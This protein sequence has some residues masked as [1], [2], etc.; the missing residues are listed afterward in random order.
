[1]RDDTREGKVLRV[2]QNDEC[3]IVQ[4][5][6]GQLERFTLIP[7]GDSWSIVARSWRCSDCEGNGRVGKNAGGAAGTACPSGEG[8]GWQTLD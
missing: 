4:A 1:M 8:T 5:Q 2:V 3:A 7:N 6:T